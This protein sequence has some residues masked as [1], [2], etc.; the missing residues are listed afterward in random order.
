MIDLNLTKKKEKNNVVLFVFLFILFLSRQVLRVRLIF[1]CCIIFS[2]QFDSHHS[3]ATILE[4]NTPK[5]FFEET[6]T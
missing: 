2:V 5:T 6:Q 4:K 1:F 3:H